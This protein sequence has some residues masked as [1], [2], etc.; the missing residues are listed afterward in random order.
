MGRNKI[1]WGTKWE[2]NGKQ[3]IIGLDKM[4]SILLYCVQAVYIRTSILAGRSSR[5]FRFLSSLST[6]AAAAVSMSP[7]DRCLG[8]LFD[9]CISG[10]WGVWC[11]L[12]DSHLVTAVL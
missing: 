10:V 4:F 9:G 5:N 2:E 8:G 3:D 12:N 1:D 7:A 11:T 6:A